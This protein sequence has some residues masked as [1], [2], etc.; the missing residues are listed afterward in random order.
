[1]TGSAT[2]PHRYDRRRREVCGDEKALCPPPPRRTAY[3]IINHCRWD[4]LTDFLP[5][6]L[7]KRSFHTYL[8][9]N[10]DANDVAPIPIL[11]R[12]VR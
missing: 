11:Y 6:L 5:A 9:A 7:L 10:F 3:T 1:M 4:R 12:R 2:R 8:Q